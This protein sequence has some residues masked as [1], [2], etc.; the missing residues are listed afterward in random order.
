ML[1]LTV[2]IAIISGCADSK[3]SD[4]ENVILKIEAFEKANGRLP[5]NLAEIGIREAEDGPV[6]YQMNNPHSY[7]L[8]YGTTLGESRVYDSSSSAWK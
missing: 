4:A 1:T 7:I 6:F 5:E 2:F 8:W 3:K